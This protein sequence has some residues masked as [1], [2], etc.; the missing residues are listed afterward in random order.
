MFKI[1]IELSWILKVWAAGLAQPM[2]LSSYSR[3]KVVFG[4]GLPK[5]CEEGLLLLGGVS[6]PP[7]SGPRTSADVILPGGKLRANIETVCDGQLATS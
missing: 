1:T 6:I 2:L 4:P 3:N 7:R 5:P